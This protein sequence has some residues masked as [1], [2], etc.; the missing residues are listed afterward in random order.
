MNFGSQINLFFQD[1]TFSDL[2]EMFLAPTL[3]GPTHRHAHY[4]NWTLKTREGKYL[5]VNDENELTISDKPTVFRVIFIDDNRQFVKLFVHGKGYVKVSQ[6]TVFGIASFF[7][8]V[9]FNEDSS[10]YHIWMRERSCLDKRE[11]KQQRRQRQR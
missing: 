10:V 8:I 11:L 1:D 6:I 7:G 9:I 3:M 4:A 5:S 2:V